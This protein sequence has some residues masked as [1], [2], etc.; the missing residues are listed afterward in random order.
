MHRGR[1]GPRRRGH[2]QRA[3]LARLPTCASPGSGKGVGRAD[4]D[5]DTGARRADEELA[6]VHGSLSV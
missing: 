1:Q 5:T 4:D 6:S 3:G 2:R